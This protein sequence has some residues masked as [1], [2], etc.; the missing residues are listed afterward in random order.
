MVQFNQSPN[1]PDQMSNL[2][3]P[4]NEP[5]SS[6]LQIL[7]PQSQPGPT[8]PFDTLSI[9]DYYVRRALVKEGG[10]FAFCLIY[11]SHYFQLEPALFH[12]ELAINLEDQYNRFLEIIGAR[13]VAKSTYGSLAF[14]V[15]AALEQPEKYPFIIPVA[16]T[17]AQSSMNIANIKN[18]LENN[19]L[20][21]QDYG[22]IEFDPVKDDSPEDPTLESGE[23]WQ[24]RNMLL[25]NGV[26]ILARSRGQKIRGLRHRQHRPKLIVVDDPEDLKWV[27]F[28]ENRDE[29]D[30]WMRGEVIPSI[31]TLSGR[32]ILIGNYLHDDA[33]MS[34]IKKLGIFKTLEYPLINDAGICQWP[35]Q[36]PTQE[37]IDK[38]RK[39]AGETAW[40]R[41]YMLKVVPD[42]GAEVEPKDIHYYDEFPMT[43]IPGTNQIAVDDS[44][45][46]IRG[47]GVDL[48]ISTKASADYTSVVSGDVFHVDEYPKIYIIPHPTNA[49]MDFHTTIETLRLVPQGGGAHLFF[50]ESVAYQL[51]AIQEMERAGMPVIAIKPMADKRSRLRV[52]A[53]YIKNGTVLFPRTG[54]EE[55][56]NQLLNF[57]VEKHDDMADAFVYLITGLV[58]RG[59]SLPKI[60]WL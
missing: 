28:K 8:L 3:N 19:K 6:Q 34:R 5:L 55:L 51:A 39:L 13:G 46:G 30:K 54:C 26:R 31:D 14:P 42:E 12:P 29:T 53:R 2:S 41:E 7:I 48:A 21:L 35:A 15:Y 47:H 57:G 4:S 1:L 56:L 52:V 40:Q 22:K 32:I 37:S 60:M 59:L 58:E 27:R 17:S 43:L 11:F 20:L 33:L 9:N 44:L 38:A 23:E 18:E 25:N 50:V 36:Y 24:A 16:D 45:R 49:H 10:F